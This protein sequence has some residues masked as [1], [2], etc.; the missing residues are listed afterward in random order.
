MSDYAYIKLQRENEWLRKELH[1]MQ[2]STAYRLGR[3]LTFLPHKAKTLAYNYQL[4]K[5]NTL[6]KESLLKAKSHVPINEAGHI[7]LTFLEDGSWAN[8][9]DAFLANPKIYKDGKLHFRDIV[10]PIPLNK[11]DCYIFLLSIFESCFVYLL[12]EY[13]G[14]GYFLH[15]PNEMPYECGTVALKKND[16]VIDAGSCMGEFAALAGVRGCIAFAFEPI[17][18][19]IE[20]YLKKTAEWNKSIEICEY[21]LSDKNG[22]LT[23][24]IDASMIGSSS[25]LKHENETESIR[26]KAITLDDFVQK[27]N[28][29]RVDFIKADIEGAER[30]MLKGAKNV[31]KEFAPKLAICT[32]HLPDDPQVIRSI[33]L[34]ANPRYVIEDRQDKLF[35]YVP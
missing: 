28:L 17:P 6:R 2:N 11:S 15:F 14:G 8:A 32:Y 7:L 4:K 9:Y 33:I 26:V 27:R 3:Y 10:L 35:A 24:S 12:E 21:A 29:P 1:L 30:N 13:G 19:V 5:Q 34:D 31:L 23:F 16:I 22:E 25:Q 20:N 18:Y